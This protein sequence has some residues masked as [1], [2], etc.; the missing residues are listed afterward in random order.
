MIQASEQQIKDFLD[1]EF[2]G[3]PYYIG[4]GLTISS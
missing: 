2:T 4:C 3:Q 1:N